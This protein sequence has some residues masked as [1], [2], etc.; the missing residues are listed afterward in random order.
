MSETIAQRHAREIRAWI[1]SISTAV[2]DVCEVDV[3]H[4]RSRLDRQDKH[5]R[6]RQIAMYLVSKHVGL[7]AMRVAKTFGYRDIASATDALRKIEDELERGRGVAGL[8]RAAE[9]RF[10]PRSAA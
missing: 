5:V 7:T 10:A 1:T 3:R 8:V 6:A 2:A 4:V 9:L